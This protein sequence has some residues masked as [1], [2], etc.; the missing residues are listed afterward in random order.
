MPL[1]GEIHW[2][3]W[4]LW[5]DEILDIL[6]LTRGQRARA[7]GGLCNAHSSTRVRCEIWRNRRVLRFF[8]KSRSDSSRSIASLSGASFSLLAC[9]AAENVHLSRPFYSRVCSACVGEVLILLSSSRRSIRLG[10]SRKFNGSIGPE[11]IGPSFGVDSADWSHCQLLKLCTMILGN[12]RVDLLKVSNN[13][14]VKKEHIV[15]AF[16]GI[17]ICNE[18]GWGE[19]PYLGQSSDSLWIK[20]AKIT[21][22]MTFVLRNSIWGSH[23]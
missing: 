3:I 5:K 15:D 7:A 1:S 19:G 4:V 9:L 13:S 8:T 2:D 17:Y 23:A 22:I 12:V 18:G 6:V 21:K 20:F 10:K 16:M 14:R 11:F